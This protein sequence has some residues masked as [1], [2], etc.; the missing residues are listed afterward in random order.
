MPVFRTGCQF[1]LGQRSA[2]EIIEREQKDPMLNLMGKRYWFFA[3]SLLIIIPGIIIMAVWK[4]PVSIDF[5]GG[6]LLEVQ[7]AS[8]KLPEP[9]SVYQLFQSLGITNTQV[10][11]SGTDILIMRSEV[12]SE[13]NQAKI[14][15]ELGK[16]TGGAV[17]VRR[18]D[19]VGPTISQQVTQNGFLA[20]VASSLALVIFITFSFRKVQGGFVYGICTVLALLHDILVIFSIVALGGR[21]W[22][23]QV[24]TLFLTALLTV[25]AFS[26]QDTIVV[27][28]RIRENSSI[29]RRLDF[30]Q[31]VNHSVVQSMTRSINTQ[32]M[33]VDFM[34]LAL[35]LFGGVTLREFAIVLLIGMI[36]GSYSSIFVAAPLVIIW[37]T[38]E[39]R[40]WFRP[41]AT[42]AA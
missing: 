4:L 37:Q 17:V 19:T 16:M 31:L 42:S 15:A 25:I 1:K 41:R 3:L 23:W 33:T 34:L 36:S 5:K 29:F 39:W 9:A 35:A 18:A 28:D 8:G 27:F 11:T 13:D 12:V 2:I 10:L 38:G 30:E 22:G 20:V 21:L 26:A 24:D 14:L 40:N 32:L 6:S 7:I